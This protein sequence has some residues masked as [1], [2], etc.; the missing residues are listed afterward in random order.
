VGSV[1]SNAK[2]DQDKINIKKLEMA[3]D[4]RSSVFR[5]SNDAN[6]K[7][8]KV[9]KP[10]LTTF[11]FTRYELENHLYVTD[12]MPRSFAVLHPRQT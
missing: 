11:G 2:D 4:R 10:V 6:G 5:V 1:A 3:F 12:L 7:I 9:N 8:I